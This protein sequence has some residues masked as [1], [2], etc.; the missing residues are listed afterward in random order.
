MTLPHD[1]LFQIPCELM[2]FRQMR[3]S[4]ALAGGQ[5]S[6]KLGLDKIFSKE[7]SKLGSLV[8]QVVLASQVTLYYEFM[9]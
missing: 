1:K 8:C 4:V 9:Y 6:Q 2:A 7:V 5:L 3:T